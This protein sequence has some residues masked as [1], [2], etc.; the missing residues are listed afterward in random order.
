MSKKHRSTRHAVAVAVL[1]LLLVPLPAAAGYGS[2]GPAWGFDLADWWSWLTRS[3]D[4]VTAG[5]Q[6][7]PDSDPNGAQGTSPNDP[8][9]D[10]ASTTSNPADGTGETLPNIDPDG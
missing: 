4:A 1:L 6:T 8:L 9:Q 2:A 7:L 5:Q 10:P 3:W